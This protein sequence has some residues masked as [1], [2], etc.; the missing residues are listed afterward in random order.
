MGTFLLCVAAA[1][2]WQWNTH[3]IAG[4][5]ALVIMAAHF[6][7][8]LLALFKS[9]KWAVSFHRWSVAAWAVWLVAFVSGIPVGVWAQLWIAASITAMTWFSWRL[10]VKLYVPP[11]MVRATLLDQIEVL[12]A[13]VK[14]R[15]YS[16]GHDASKTFRVSFYGQVSKLFKRARKC[17]D[18]FIAE[19]SPH[20]IRC[21]LCGDP[22]FPGD[23]VALYAPD[24]TMRLDIAT[25]LPDG[26][27][28]GC[29]GWDCCDCGAFFAGN[30]SVEGFVPRFG[31]RTAGQEAMATGNTIVVNQIS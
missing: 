7:W 3:S 11:K 18:C 8:Y 30:W 15:R 20:V 19:V 5:A 1:H 13:S 6:G 12:D 10:A 24:N 9:G 31:G 23:G 28:I 17:P 16:C 2:S 22:I 29:M 26:Q 21:V 14:Q 25:T 4:L 27:V